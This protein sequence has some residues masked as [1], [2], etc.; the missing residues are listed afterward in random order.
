MAASW[1]RTTTPSSLGGSFDLGE[2]SSSSMMT[3]PIGVIGSGASIVISDKS[4]CGKA[5]TTYLR[6]SSNLVP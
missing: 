3:L 2:P 5:D 6:Q 4:N 1:A